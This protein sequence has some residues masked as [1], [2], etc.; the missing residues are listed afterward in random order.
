VVKEGQAVK[1]G[2]LLGY[3]GLSGCM[4]APHLHLNVFKIENG[5]GISVPFKLRI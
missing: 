2:E 1:T 4:S 3:T 5:K